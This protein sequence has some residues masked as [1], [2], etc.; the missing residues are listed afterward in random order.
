MICRHTPHK[1]SFNV[2]L[3]EVTSQPHHACGHPRPVTSQLYH[4]CG[5]PSPLLLC[6]LLPPG[7]F[8]FLREEESSPVPDSGLSS[9]S[10]SSSISLGGSSGNLPQMTQEVEDVDAAAETDEKANKLIEFLTTR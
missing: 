10:T 8:D 3:H 9:S 7:G 6:C 5:H 4:P 1:Q 2:T